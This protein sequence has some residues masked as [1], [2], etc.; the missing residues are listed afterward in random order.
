[1]VLRYS[2]T[3]DS[4]LLSRSNVLWP[5]HAGVCA[6]LHPVAGR[7][8]DRPGRTEGALSRPE[9]TLLTGSQLTRPGMQ[10][11]PTK[12]F[13]ANQLLRSK[14]SGTLLPFLSCGGGQGSPSATIPC[15]HFGPG[16]TWCLGATAS[17]AFTKH[18]LSSMEGSWVHTRMHAHTHA[19]T[20]ATRSPHRP[21]G[22]TGPGA[23]GSGA[24][25]GR[26]H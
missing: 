4:D 21:R 10:Q 8:P 18:P 7:A 23:S 2:R 9:K 14:D 1:M 22:S 12:A 25:G 26:A 19:H 24:E 5:L 15:R 17:Y 13:T 11:F 16:S 6:E 20:P 3:R